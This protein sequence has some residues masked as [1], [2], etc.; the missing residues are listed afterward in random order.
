MYDN[1]PSHAA[2]NPSSAL[3]IKGD[4]LMVQPPSSPDL[5]PIENLWSI[6]KPK[7][8]EG[9]THRSGNMSK[10]GDRKLIHIFPFLM[11]SLVHSALAEYSN[12][13][14]NEYYNLTT[15]LCHSCPMCE[16]GEEP[17]YSC[18]YGTKDDDYCCTP[19]PPDKYSKG[20]YQICRRHK[21][22]EIFFRATVLT[23]GDS[24]NDAEC[25]PCLPGFYL[26]ES[27]PKSIHEMVC[28]PCT[29]APPSVKECF[30][31]KKRPHKRPK[32]IKR[33]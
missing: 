33:D 31:K 11:V 5:N 15:G 27:R 6:I 32:C 29:A 17:N 28:Q 8:Y 1:A 25:G 10:Q 9:V 13:G 20:G 30:K 16:P 24:K 4:K 22:C 12:C 19:C 7:I 21:D 2:K 23:P 26:L 14:E 18:G 3:G